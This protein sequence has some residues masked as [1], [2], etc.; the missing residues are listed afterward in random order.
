MQRQWHIT[1]DL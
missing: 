1:V